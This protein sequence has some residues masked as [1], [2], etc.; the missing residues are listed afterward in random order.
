[1]G[2]DE[3]VKSLLCKLEDVSANF[4]HAPGKTDVALCTCNPSSGE[5]ETG[6]MPVSRAKC[7]SFWFSE[8]YQLTNMAHTHTHIHTEREREREKYLYQ[9]KVF[10]VV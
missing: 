10:S 8:R 9:D 7:V 5:I 4:Q 2:L 6:F 3:L 1:M